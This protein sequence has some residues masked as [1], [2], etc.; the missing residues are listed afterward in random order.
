M[1]SLKKTMLSQS[2]AAWLG[3]QNELFQTIL[4]SADIFQNSYFQ[5]ILSGLPSAGFQV[6]INRKVGKK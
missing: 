1:L 2:G 4:L 5:N 3:S 6:P